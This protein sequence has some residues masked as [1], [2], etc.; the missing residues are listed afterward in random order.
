[1][2]LAYSA[3]AFVCVSTNEKCLVVWCIII[4]RISYRNPKKKYF[5]NCN[6]IWK[7]NREKLTQPYYL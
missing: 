6:V 4:G 5:K 7:V 1:M 3:A 2:T